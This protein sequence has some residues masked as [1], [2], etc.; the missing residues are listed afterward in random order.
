MVS[1]VGGVGSAVELGPTGWA[2]SKARG[3][4]GWMDNGA[5][6]FLFPVVDASTSTWKLYVVT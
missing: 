2:V 6:L 5:G 1:T 4:L 3:G